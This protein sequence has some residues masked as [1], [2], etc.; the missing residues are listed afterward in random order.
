MSDTKKKRG[1]LKSLWQTMSLLRLVVRTVVVVGGGWIAYSR[2]FV[3]RKLDL[4]HALGGERRTFS[5]GEFALS[6]YATGEGK[7]LVLLHSINAAA[8]AYEMKPIY[9]RFSASHRVYALDLP[10]F[11]FS[12]RPDTEYTPHLYKEAVLSFIRS[13]VAPEGGSADVVALSLGCEFAARAAHEAP[14]L[15]KSLTLI[16]PSGFSRRKRDAAPDRG[17]SFLSFLNTPL[18][19]RAFY[20]LLVTRRSLRFYLNRTFASRQ[21]DQG[22]IDYAYQTAHQPGARHA[23][24]Y[25]IS[26]RLFSPDIDDIYAS[27]NIP[28]LVLYDRDPFVG[29]DRLPEYE[30]RPNWSL[31]RIEGTRGLPHFEKPDETYEVLAAFLSDYASR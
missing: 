21:A 22:L 7:P 14:E 8:S 16:S 20:D 17:D 2:F 10:G 13:E 3:P 15:F 5:L 31:V 6:Y 11:G 9:E 28:V 18:W 1:P 30:K 27:L 29:F 24:F 25:F 19:S 12:S 23:P 4:A 26:G